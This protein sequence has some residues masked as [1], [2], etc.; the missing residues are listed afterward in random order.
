MNQPLVTVIST[1]FN[2]AP[3]LR[4][5]LD[6]VKNQSYRNIQH[7]VIDGG[8]TDGTVEI[9]KSYPGIEYIS[10]RDNGPLHAVLKGIARAK[11]EYIMFCPVTDGYLDMRWIERCVE[12][13]QRDPEISLVWGLP[14]YK[15]SDGSLGPVSYPQFQRANPPQ[16]EKFLYYWALTAFWLPEGNFCVRSHVFKDCYPVPSINYT[17][18]TIL[19]YDP[20][21]EFNYR[22]NTKGYLPYF[23]RTIASFGRRHENQRGKQETENKT[24]E[25]WL[26]AYKQKVADY[27]QQLVFH[28]NAHRFTRWDKKLTPYQFSGRTM[29]TMMF[30][31]FV[32]RQQIAEKIRTLTPHWLRDKLRWL[33]YLRLDS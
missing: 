30:S 7:L 13:M 4:E 17:R 24:G 18:Q 14:Q 25:V 10:E 22:F 12:T 6:S 21:L 23:I 26:R 3:Y 8:S 19:P 16:K 27:K 32:F 1:S 20:W 31:P 5:T 29:A 9:L 33:R 2:H 15:E 11:G 28:G